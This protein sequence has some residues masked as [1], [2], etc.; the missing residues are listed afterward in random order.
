MI[1]FYNRK[2]KSYEIEKVSGEKLLN[3]LYNSKNNKLL[4]IITKNK[5]VSY[6]YGKYCDME[7]SKLKIKSFIE[8][9]N[10]NIDESL[11]SINEFKS[12]NEFFTRKLKS[13]S[14]T[15]HGNNNILISPA[16]SKVLAFENI[17]I[18]KIIQVKGSYYSFEELLNSNK[19]CE[20]YRDGSCLIFR[21][22]PTDYHRF[23][24]V[25]SGICT[26]TTKINGHY[27]SVN[28]RALQKIP[29]LFCKNKREWSI[30]KSDNFGDIL[31]IEIGAT[32][33][34]TIVQ[35]YNPNKKVSKGQEKGYFKF[36]GSTIILFFEKNKI[37][38][39][40]DI[41]NQ[42]NLGYESK[43]LVGDKIGKKKDD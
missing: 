17:D 37:F 25:D 40:K 6:F 8:N 18:K 43:V 11:K 15:I 22:C 41:I 33:V 1:K 3:L 29:S 27:Y 30:L 12:F 5:F 39:D 23:H 19:L 28:P 31:Y 16:D 35:T 36:G 2:T 42:S 20:K 10:I 24:F 13:N 7:I 38:I 34:G 21:L 32:C 14:R 4:N 9:F 26:K